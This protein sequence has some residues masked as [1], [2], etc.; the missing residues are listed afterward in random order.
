MLPFIIALLFLFN[1]GNFFSHKTAPPPA[2]P[3]PLACV[4]YEP[5]AR[6]YVDQVLEKKMPTLSPEKRYELAT[7]IEQESAVAGIDTIMILSVIEFESNF[8]PHAISSVGAM[9]MMQL[10]PGTILNVSEVEGLPNTDA[11]DP[12]TNVK[13]GIKYLAR[14]KKSFK[15]WDSALM[16]YNAGPG[17][18]ISILR[19]QEEFPERY[20]EYP[21][22]VHQKYAFHQRNLNR[23]YV[24]MAKIDG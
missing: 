2:R 9:G 16:A 17:R 6:S 8:N 20:L 13:A 12:I 22:G 14:V 7:V 15:K 21:R 3:E 1:W 23:Y 11:F 24:A 5:R 18:I 10:M 4:S 19:A